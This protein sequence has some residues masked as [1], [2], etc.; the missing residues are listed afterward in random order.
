MSCI[1]NP[2]HLLFIKYNGDHDDRV[3]RFGR[4]MS[5][6]K[7]FIV[8]YQCSLCGRQHKDSFVSEEQLLA[9]GVSID[10]IR[11]QRNVIF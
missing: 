1:N 4:F 9:K 11:K 6:S 10:E 8:L 5:E 3:I 2:K 7:Y